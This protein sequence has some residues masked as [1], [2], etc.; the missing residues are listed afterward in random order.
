MKHL[1][2]LATV[3][4]VLAVFA[5]AILI[6]WF[7]YAFYTYDLGAHGTVLYIWTT[8]TSWPQSLFSTIIGLF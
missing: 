1:I 6:S 2:R 8:I 4:L 5:T 3:L 7:A